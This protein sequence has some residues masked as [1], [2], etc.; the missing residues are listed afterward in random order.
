M[1]LLLLLLLLIAAVGVTRVVPAADMWALGCL[2]YTLCYCSHPFTDATQ[3]QIVNANVRY[4]KTVP[5]GQPVAPLALAV[6]QALL[7][8]QVPPP[9]S[10]PSSHCSFAP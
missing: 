2:L 10:P 1:L 3:L 7:Q 6:I 5:G 9:R 8:Q 4:P